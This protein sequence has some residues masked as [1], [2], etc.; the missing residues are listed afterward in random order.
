MRKHLWP[1]G[2]AA[3][4]LSPISVLAQQTTDTLTLEQALELA[5]SRSFVVSAAQ[6]ELEA[7]DGSVRQA[8]AFRNPELAASVEDTRS[9]TRTTTTTLNIPLELGGKRAARVS[10]AERARDLAQ[11]ELANA[12]AQVRSSAIAAYF[13]VLAA[14]ERAKLAS[15]SA[16]LASSGAQAVVKRVTAGKVSPV[17]A[18]R[19]QVDQANAELE[20][21]EAQAELTTARHALATLWGDTEP[22][23]VRVAGDVN[24]IPERSPL[25]ELMSRLE[26]APALLAARTEVERRK[27]LVNV[28]RSKGVPDVT[29]SVG[30]KRDN[31]M[32]R[33]QAIVGLSIPLPLF[34]RN[35]GAVYEASKRADKAEDEFQAA[36]LR[37][38]ADLQTA[39]TQLSIARTSLQ[40]LQ[41]TVLPAAQRAYESASQGFDAGKFGFLDVIDAQRSLLQ[42]RA[43]YL[44]TL[45]NAYQAATAIDRLLGR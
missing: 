30:A 37:V 44:S 9:A 32:G 3:A 36:R 35:Q 8:G 28:E 14:Q 29:L 34:D 41:S 45:S 31:E 38:L 17:D 16:E 21:A 39:A 15:N 1:L 20:A 10:A 18:T 40:A 22:R 19:A 11:V 25:P 7:Q 2:L 23:F 33:T 5:T 42:A 13:A 26:E 4:L 12:K 24:A 6:R 27:A 43:R